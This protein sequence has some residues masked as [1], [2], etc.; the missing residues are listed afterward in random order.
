MRLAPVPLW[1]HVPGGNSLGADEWRASAHDEALR[2][3]VALVTDGAP[4]SAPNARGGQ[5]SERRRV[6]SYPRLAEAR[7]VAVDT[8]Q[9]S[10]L[11]RISAP[12][13]FAAAYARVRRDP[14]WQ[15]VFAEDGVVVMRRV[16]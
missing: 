10:Y 9:A 3:A 16:E 1:A 14:R 5:L 6:F 13:A 15:V 11:D 2:R 4:V 7:W 8:R 12:A